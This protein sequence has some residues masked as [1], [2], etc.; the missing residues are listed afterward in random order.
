MKALIP[1]GG[2]GTRL[3]PITHTSAKQLVPVANKPILFYVLDDI[4]EAGVT[5]TGIVVGDTADEIRE[6]VGDGSA[7]DLKVTYIEQ[8]APLGL[9]HTVLI[10]RDFLGEDPFVMYLGDNLLRD[11]IG[12]FVQRFDQTGCSAQ[13]MVTPVEQPEHYGVAVLDGERVVRLVEKPKEPVSDLALV[14]VYLFDA[15]V[16]DAVRALKPSGRGELEIT[17]AIQWL[18]DQGKDVQVHRVEG[19]W[20]DTGQPEDLLEANRLV[21]EGSQPSNDGEVDAAS[22]LS[23]TVILQQ[24]ARIVNSKLRGPLIIGPN[25]VIKDSFIGPFTSIGA[26]CTV[27]D[28]EIEHSVIM[29]ECRLRGVRRLEDSLL[30]RGVVVERSDERPRSYQLMVGDSGRV[31]LI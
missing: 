4:A 25:T 31:G 19:W 28:S 21:L 20:K 24:G 2:A 7:W 17:E 10:A 26:D 30:G 3:R 8:E 22:K 18:L 13:I 12:S 29:E 6:A 11:G 16:H 14:G 23:G 5:E 9:A 15:S 27:E 1:S